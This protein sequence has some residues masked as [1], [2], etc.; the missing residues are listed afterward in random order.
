[1]DASGNLYVTESANSHIYRVTAGALT[2]I[3][4]GGSA[5]N[6]SSALAARLSGPTGIA[7]NS[8]G[9]VWFA[10]TGNNTIQKL[11]P[12]A[13]AP[14]LGSGGIVGAGGSVPAVQNAAPYG[15]IT[16]WGS[17]FAPD[18]TVRFVGSRD[19]VNGAWPTNL[20]GVCVL[21][22]GT[23]YAPVFQLLPSQV[24]AQVPALA[25]GSTAVFQVLRNC[26]TSSEVASNPLSVAVQETAPE[27]F[28]FVQNANGVNSIAALNAITG[29]R[30]GKAGL[31]PGVSFTPAKPG[32]WLALY[33][34]GF[35]V[36]SP[37]YA[38]GAIP[39]GAA[40]TVL[41]ARVRF[42]GVEL[43]D[44]QVIYTGIAPGI[45]GEYQVNLQVPPG[46]AD[47][48]YCVVIEIGGAS[49]PAGGYISVKNGQ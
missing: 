11:V 41:K 13:A 46:L 18:G 28:Y 47:G 8:A 14:Q 24:G 29:E 26:G 22:N 12:W 6:A 17:N 34:T 30:I 25:A 42:G 19:L 1:V 4:G 2:R 10:D 3:A 15:L 21:V 37:A 33:G 39:G 31:I 49:T 23:E 27:F 7:V 9:E 44:A 5:V 48:D 36:T 35:G 43:N 38:P 20:A 32:D 40:P 16:I 45:P